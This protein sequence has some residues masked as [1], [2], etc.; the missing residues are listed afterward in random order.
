MSRIRFEIFP[1]IES[2]HE[3]VFITGGIPELGDW[4]PRSALALRWE[5]PVHVGV[6]D[7]QSGSRFEYKITRGSWEREA[8][9]AWGNVPAN[10]D[11]TPL[12]D[13][14]IWK[15][16]ADWKDRY[17]GRLTTDRVWSE[18]LASARDLIV[19]VPPEYASRP[20]QRFP[21]I[22]LFDGDNVFDP[23]TSPLSGM[24]WAAD[25]WSRQLTQ[26]GV[27]PPTI[28][29]AVRHPEGHGEDGRSM[30]EIDLS[31]D[32]AG[33]A[34][35]DFAASELVGYIDSRYRTLRDP[36]ARVLAGSAL[37]GLN[38]FVTALNHTGIF[39]RAVCFSTSF[40]DTAEHLP[41]QCPV[42]QRL[43]AMEKMPSGIRMF[44]A[45]GD[46]GIDE[47]YEV[48]HRELGS[49]LRERGWQDGREFRIVQMKGGVHGEGSWRLWLG[50]ALA[51]V[52]GRSSS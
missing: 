36:S 26:E 10:S 4:H 34:F 45:Y 37:G 38:V 1:P 52:C 39:G 30:R 35:S 46:H 23:A 8:V 44:F 14:T 33:Q 7:V 12:L 42:L 20:G 31:M 43:D 22:Y 51:F 27:L 11:F 40:E 9:D 24:D 17:S 13:A 41:G 18:H 29:V 49:L 28:V 16:V 32:Y 48:Y 21:V 25:E 19:W 2:P 6:I 50:D 5:A 3:P 15:T 47:C